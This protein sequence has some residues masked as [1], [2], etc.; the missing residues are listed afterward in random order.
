MTNLKKQRAESTACIHGALVRTCTLAGGSLTSKQK[1]WG[2]FCADW[3]EH[4]WEGGGH[5]SETL[6]SDLAQAHPSAQ[7]LMRRR[8][9]SMRG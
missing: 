2:G 4:G 1:G 7:S 9:L 8:V 5:P 6:W 3:G